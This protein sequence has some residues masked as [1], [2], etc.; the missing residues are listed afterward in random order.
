[1][2]SD[3]EAAPSQLVVEGGSV[4]DCPLAGPMRVGR[5]WACRFHQSTVE[6]GDL[7]VLCGF[8]HRA[9]LRRPAEAGA[10]SEER[11]AAAR[12][13]RSPGW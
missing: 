3:Y 2:T 1:M 9:P 6:D 8:T 5:C 10:G 11:D 7:V 4:P 12:R 13:L